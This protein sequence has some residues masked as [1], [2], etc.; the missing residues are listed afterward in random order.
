MNDGGQAEKLQEMGSAAFVPLRITPVGPRPFRFEFDGAQASDVGLARIATTSCMVRRTPDLIT[1][2][3]PELVKITL[4][5]RGRSGIEQDGRQCLLTPGDLSVYTSDRP[6]ELAFTEPYE[7]IAI[8]VP[9]GHLGAHADVLQ[10]QSAVRLTTDTALRR[11]ISG[12][13]RAMTDTLRAGDAEFSGSAGRHLGDAVTSLIISELVGA[14]APPTES[15]LADQILAYCMTR[16]SDPALCVASV[17][18][19]HRISVRYL[20]KLFQ[21]RG[22]SLAAWIRHQRLLGI[23]RDLAD[24]ALAGRTVASISARWGV[25]SASHLSRALKAE[26]GCT[27]ADIRRAVPIDPTGG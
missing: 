2:G 7:I 11:V 13:F 15:D 27:A 24:P 12:L 20:H 5:T 18:Q 25:L 26:F 19:A 8:G 16:L 14:S 4:Q 3:D 17:A 1:S 6:Y 23:R 9:R 10:R 21:A 22:L